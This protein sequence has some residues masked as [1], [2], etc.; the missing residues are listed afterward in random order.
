MIVGILDLYLHW[1]AYTMANKLDLDNALRSIMQNN[2]VYFQPPSKERMKYP[3]IVYSLDDINNVFANNASYKQTR[4]Y[5]VILIDANPDSAFID[6]LN[7]L[8]C[9][10]VRHYVT[11]QLNHFVFTIKY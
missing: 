3:A 7:D 11:D 9:K 5:E 4:S 1:G 6:K 2:N 8:G 10:F